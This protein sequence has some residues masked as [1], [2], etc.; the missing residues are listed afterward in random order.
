[1]RG[2][3]LETVETLIEEWEDEDDAIMGRLEQAVDERAYLRVR[4]I[5]DDLMW[6]EIYQLPEFAEIKEIIDGAAKSEKSRIIL[7]WALHRR[8]ELLKEKLAGQDYGQLNYHPND[9]DINWIRTS[10]LFITVVSKSKEPSEIPGKLLDAIKAW[11][12]QPHRLLMS[13][14][15][16]AMDESG[17]CA[18][19][20]VLRNRCL[21]AGWLEDLV[22]VEEEERLWK[23]GRTLSRHWERLGDTIR[24]R[25]ENFSERLAGHLSSVGKEEMLQRYSPFKDSHRQRRDDVVMALNSYVCSKPVDGTHLTTGHILKFS[26]NEYWLC[27]TPACDLVP[28]QKKTGWHGRL[29]DHMPFTAVELRKP[30]RNK[31]LE[32]ATDGS[33]LF[34][35][36]EGNP[37]TLC[38][39]D[40]SDAD[41]SPPNPKI[42]QFFAVNGG[43]FERGN[44]EVSLLRIEAEDDGLVMR[45]SQTSV[46]AQLR[47]EYALNL[48]QRLGAAQ[49]RVGLDFESYS[50]PSGD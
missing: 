18:E 45:H 35:D 38:F 47:Y 46:V 15:R 32:K 20:E 36:V 39:V 6:N 40:D 17:V 5:P 16:S 21:Q 12:P 34:L 24:P 26:H 42:E 2:P 37:L 14:M 3:S 1:M 44:P 9:E 43:R 49:T 4:N 7:K 33:Y 8:Q 27:L 28:G 25:M 11:E 48:L 31:A 13:K 19:D 30:N 22:T 41:K 50:P 10:R 23:V 29:R